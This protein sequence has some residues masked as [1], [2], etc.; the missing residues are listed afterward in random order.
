MNLIDFINAKKYIRPNEII[1]INYNVLK[2]K[3]PK[4]IVGTVISM[5]NN[6]LKIEEQPEPLSFEV[7]NWIKIKVEKKNER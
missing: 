7:I 6:E 1:L 4:E 3:R 2:C 5:L